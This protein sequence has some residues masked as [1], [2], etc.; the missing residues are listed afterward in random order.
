[1]FLFAGDATELLLEEMAIGVYIFVF[2][3]RSFGDGVSYNFLL[4]LRGV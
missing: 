1:V 4:I 2:L 3:P